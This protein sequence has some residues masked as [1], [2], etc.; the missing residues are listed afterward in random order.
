[1]RQTWPGPR[2]CWIAVP[3]SPPCLLRPPGWTPRA[4]A[5]SSGQTSGRVQTLECARGR[6]VR[7]GRRGGSREPREA[8]ALGGV[9]CTPHLGADLGLQLAGSGRLANRTL[10]ATALRA[11]LTPAPAAAAAALPLGPAALQNLRLRGLGT[12]CPPLPAPPRDCPARVWFPGTPPV[13][14]THALA[15]PIRPAGMATVFQPTIPLPGQRPLQRTSRT[16]SLRNSCS[17]GQVEV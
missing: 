14:V 5:S 6:G 4:A 13:P 12:T 7:G 15:R 9:A 8:A 16:S 17:W 1:M 3:G 11:V 10:P 2:R